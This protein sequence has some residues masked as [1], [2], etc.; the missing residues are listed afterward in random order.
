[1][2]SLSLEWVEK[3]VKELR[4]QLENDVEFLT[5][6]KQLC[7]LELI[8]NEIIDSLQPEQREIATRFCNLNLQMEVYLT[9]V[10]YERGLRAGS[11]QTVSNAV[12]Y[13]PKH[14]NDF[15]S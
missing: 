9:Y 2:D 3:W 14:N 8:Y 13:L 15:S 7:E 6:H 11:S 4:N 12:P 1:M 10:C 5:L